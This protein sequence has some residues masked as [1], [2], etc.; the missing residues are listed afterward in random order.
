[1]ESCNETLVLIEHKQV[2]HFHFNRKRVSFL[3]VVIITES[4]LM[5][6]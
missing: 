6:A 4:H 2:Y 5:T 3:H 1:M